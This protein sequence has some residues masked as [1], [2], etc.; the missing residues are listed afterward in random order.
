MSE[1]KVTFVLSSRL[2]S[3]ESQILIL[4]NVSLESFGSHCLQ[5]LEN[6]GIGNLGSGV[7]T[8]LNDGSQEAE[9]LDYPAGK[10]VVGDAENEPGVLHGPG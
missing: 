4:V 1:L 6:L 9:K 8:S 10:R 2:G 7:L 5:P 3:Q